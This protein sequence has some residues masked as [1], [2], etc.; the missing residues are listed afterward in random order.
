MHLPYGF[1]HIDA[2]G[3]I[4]IDAL[5]FACHGECSFYNIFVNTYIN[6]NVN[7]QNSVNIK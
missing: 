1:R 5:D 7:M 3:I 4:Y 2:R 6:I